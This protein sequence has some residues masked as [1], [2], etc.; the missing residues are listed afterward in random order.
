ML[1]FLFNWFV[2]AGPLNDRSR[3]L[4]A[5]TLPDLFA[6]HFRERRPLVRVLSV[7]VIAVAMWLYVAAQFAAAGKSFS[8]AFNGVDYRFG[9]LIGAGIVLVYTV[10]GG[11]R[12]V[13]WTDFVQGLLMV[14]TLVVFPLYLLGAELLEMFPVV[15]LLPNVGLGVALMSYNGTVCWGLNA[16]PELVPD[17]AVFKRMLVESYERVAEAAEVKTLTP[18]G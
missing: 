13:C 1:G 10:T 5:I 14:G 9:V 12:A 3:E 8:A 11:F 16:D 17:L 18:V 2:L 6:F 4:G 7:T 15:P